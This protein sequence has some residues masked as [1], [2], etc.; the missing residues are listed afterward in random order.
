MLGQHQRFIE[1]GIAAG[2]LILAYL[3]LLATR[4][5]RLHTVRYGLPA[6][7]GITVLLAHSAVDY[8]L[9]T[10]SLATI[11]GLLSAL[12]YSSRDVRREPEQAGI[13]ARQTAD[14]L[15]P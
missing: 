13:T 2:T 8:P 15:V 6:A 10:L 5:V 14:S 11:F 4:M 1:G 9:R 3:V 12:L 7:I